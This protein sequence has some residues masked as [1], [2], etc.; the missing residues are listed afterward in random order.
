MPDFDMDPFQPLL[1]EL[2]Y[3][4]GSAEFLAK[5]VGFVFNAIFK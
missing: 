5:G 3:A 4:W 1:K 2:E